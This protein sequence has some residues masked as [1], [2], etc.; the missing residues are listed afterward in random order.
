MRYNS[1]IYLLPK[2]IQVKLDPK[3]LETTREPTTD[4]FD[5]DI[6]DNWYTNLKQHNK[7]I[8]LMK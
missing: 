4:N 5:Q 7:Y 6:V 8:V 2:C 3:G 1:H